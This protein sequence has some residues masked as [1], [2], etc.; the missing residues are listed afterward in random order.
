MFLNDLQSFLEKENLPGV[1]T[2]SE[3]YL[4]ARGVVIA[5][6]RKLDLVRLCEAAE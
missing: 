3:Q 5:N 4:R 6:Q 2:I 1:K